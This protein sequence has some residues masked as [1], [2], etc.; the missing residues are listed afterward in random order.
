[1]QE[2]ADFKHLPVAM[3]RLDEG[4]EIVCV[5]PRF[6][7]IFGCAP[8]S[9]LGKALDELFSPKDRKGA[10]TFLNRVSRYQ[11]GM[12]DG[13]LGLRI[14]GKET[15]ARVRMKKLDPGW[16]VYV[17]HALVERDLIYEMLLA[18]ERW[19]SIFSGSDDGI[20]LLNESH[21]IV[22]CNARFLEVMKLRSAHGVLLSED[23]V[24][25][26]DFFELVRSPELDRMRKTMEQAVAR[27]SASIRDA[28]Q[29][30]G[31][32]IAA[33]MRPIRLPLMGG[34]GSC[35]MARD[36]T[37]QR[38]LE[39]LRIQEAQAHWA[40]MAE[41]ATN[42]LHNLGNLCTTVIFDAEEMVRVLQESRMP[43]LFKANDIMAKHL[44]IAQQALAGHP[45]LSLLPEY[46]V[47][48]GEAL[49]EEVRASRERA[50]ELLNRVQLMKEVIA[51]QQDYAK[52]V[53]L[54]ELVSVTDILEDSLKIQQAALERHGVVVVRKIEK[55]R[56]VRAQRTKLTHVFINLIKNAKEAM[57]KTEPGYRVLTVEVT[58]KVERGVSVR[59]S[60]TGEGI[61]PDMLDKIF[62][63]GFTTKDF[64]H[65]FGLH[66]CAT[67]MMEMGGRLSVESDSARQGATFLLVFPSSSV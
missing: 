45:K 16:I 60:D 33:K 22:E 5:D 56:P 29:Y 43:R 4:Q 55:V 24:L 38:Q 61:P 59:I 19:N 13:A 66:F 37:E 62:A 46:Y 51:S 36:V 3:L 58:S 28:F 25:G 27:D 42:V 26:R 50:R 14:A 67:A 41:V 8:E 9:V 15:Y 44:Q 65:G 48:L 31:R 1:M 2:P 32:F 49:R 47:T 7:E 10:Q 52:G 39:E 20:V 11:G 35:I 21:R 53:A 63:H 54:T 30:N 40:G 18:Q 57:D 34:I 6:C 64:G 17:E 23:A 12:I